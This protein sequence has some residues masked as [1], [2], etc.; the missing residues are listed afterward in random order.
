MGVNSTF[1]SNQ[2]GNVRVTVASVNATNL[3][4]G[5]KLDSPSLIGSTSASAPSIYASTKV[6]VGTYVQMG[7]KQFIVFGSAPNEALVVAAATNVAKA[8][9]NNASVRG[10]M[11]LYNGGTSGSNCK[12]WFFTSDAQASPVGLI[13][14]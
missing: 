10:S 13:S 5:T 4:I 1:N 8:V 14:D 6:K 2:R 11:Y 12:L 3:K 9:N 7:S